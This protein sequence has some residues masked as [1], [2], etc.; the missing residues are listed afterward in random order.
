MTLKRSKV[1][2][3]MNIDNFMIYDFNPQYQYY[4]AGHSFDRGFS[5][6]KLGD[7]QVQTLLEVEANQA[8]FPLAFS[9]KYLLFIESM[10]DETNSEIETDR[11]I[12]SYNESKNELTY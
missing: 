7:Q 10:Y 6:I 12:V 3:E 11:K 9:D 4:T 1:E 2:K 8:I 5:I